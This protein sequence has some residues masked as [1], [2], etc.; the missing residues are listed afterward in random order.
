MILI[1]SMSPAGIAMLAGG[2]ALFVVALVLLVVYAL[3]GQ[4]IKPLIALLMLAILMI[5]FPSISHLQ[6]PAFSF[7]T[8]TA[9]NFLR[10]PN[11]PRAVA[12]YRATLRALDASRA[13][14]AQALLSAGVRSNLLATAGLAARSAKLSPEAYIAVSHA[15]FLLGDTN[16]A[17]AT[18][19]E[20]LK[21]NPN[22][23]Q[24]IDPRLL[25]LVQPV[26][27]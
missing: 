8:K 12:T 15:Q 1:A 18:L 13:T 19:A 11:D 9:A 3:K 14:N 7:D 25:S 6:T 5:G 22:L 16:Q 2:I 4:P 20:A 21:A 24:S 26:S 10:S 27:H 17:R 23:I